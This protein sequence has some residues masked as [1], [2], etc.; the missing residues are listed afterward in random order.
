MST[1]AGSTAGTT[2][3]S[4]AGT[5]ADPT[6]GTTA[7]TVDPTAG[8]TAGTPADPT[9]D[10]DDDDKQPTK[11]PPPRPDLSLVAQE[12]TLFTP[13]APAAIVG[14]VDDAKAACSALRPKK[15]AKLSQWRLATSGE[16]LKFKGNTDVQKLAYWVSDPGSAGRAKRVALVTGSV[17]EGDPATFTRTR[18]FCVTKR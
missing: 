5:P 2:A 7:G 12:G 9:A 15:F 13:K 14:T 3:G 8:T 11:L 18:P 16:V 4:T 1:T 17:S 10:D 6:A